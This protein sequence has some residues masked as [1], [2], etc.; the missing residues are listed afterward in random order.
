VSICGFTLYSFQ[1]TG[2]SSELREKVWTYH[3]SQ[4]HSEFG[5]TDGPSAAFG[6]NQIYFAAPRRITS[7][8]KREYL[9]CTI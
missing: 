1:M 3:E 5:A 6:R 4:K 7:F 8:V 2:D 9:M